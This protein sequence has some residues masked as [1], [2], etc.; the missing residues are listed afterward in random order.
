MSCVICFACLHQCPLNC[1]CTRTHAS[2]YPYT[3]ACTRARTH[4]HTHIY[5]HA[6]A[7]HVGMCPQDI[8]RELEGL[9]AVNPRNVSTWLAWRAAEPW[10]DVDQSHAIKS[11]G[12]AD[13]GK[14]CVM[15]R[16][17]CLQSEQ[18]MCIVHQRV[19]SRWQDVCAFS[20][21]L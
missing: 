13:G 15:G 3:Y 20:L 8:A 11:G 16:L 10:S 1:T 2:T 21:L 5:T 18:S 19:V 14:V 9:P 7:Q 12:A 4:N 17:A 6:H